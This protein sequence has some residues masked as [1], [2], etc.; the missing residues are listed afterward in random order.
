MYVCTSVY[1]HVS[2]TKVI[3]EVTPTSDPSGVL[4]T[5]TQKV[6]LFVLW[7]H[8]F[9]VPRRAV[10]RKEESAGSRRPVSRVLTPD[11]EKRRWC[12]DRHV[13]VV[14]G[15]EGSHT[16]KRC[17]RSESVTKYRVGDEVYEY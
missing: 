4:V 11:S 15:T 3:A 12:K 1:V 9:V 13:P 8:L 6:K 16:T 5:V 17:P 2:S 14:G 10:V 7:C